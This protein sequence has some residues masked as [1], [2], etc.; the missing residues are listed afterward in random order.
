MGEMYQ[1]KAT[2]YGTLFDTLKNEILSGKYRSN[3]PFP[4]VRALISRF[5]LSDRTVRHALDELYAQG[6]ISRKQGRGTYITGRCVSRKIG[7]IVPGVAYSEFYPPFLSEMNRLA[8]ENDYTLLLGEVYSKDPKTRVKQV[9]T[10]VRKFVAEGV[11][12][13][14]YQ[15]IEFLS[16]SDRIN[17]NLLAYLTSFRVPVVLIAADIVA[18][19]GR[20]E[21]DIVG[22][23]DFEAGRRIA[24]HVR[25]AGAKTVT[26]LSNAYSNYSVQNRVAGIRSVFCGAKELRELVIDPSDEK[27]VRNLFR[28]RSKTD[29]IICRSD[30]AASRLVVTLRKLGRRIPDDVML[31]GFNDVSYASML[32]LTSIRVPSD[33]IANL[34]FHQLLARMAN[35]SALT[36]ALMLPAPLTVRKS[37]DCK[38]R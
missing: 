8:S 3:F 13:I 5:K 1:M 18:S 12:G 9:Q 4:S 29:A 33:D 6:L 17:R 35:P 7:L 30:A 16:N 2:K 15:P 34:A 31:A 25:E 36:R 27:A 38:K 28:G 24:L 32:E 20:S 11:A 22:V 37:T 26:F 21:Y 19:P 23:N 10:L 14:L